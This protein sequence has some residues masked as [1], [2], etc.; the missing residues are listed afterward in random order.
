MRQ[1]PVKPETTRMDAVIDGEALNIGHQRV[2]VVIADA[3]LPRVIEIPCLLD[4]FGGLDRTTTL[5]MRS[6]WPGVY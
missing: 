2:G 4:V 3:T 5:L 6:V 1:H